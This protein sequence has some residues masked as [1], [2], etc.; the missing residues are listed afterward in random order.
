[1]IIIS[2]V[3]NIVIILYSFN[4]QL[5]VKIIEI[6][7][8]YMMYG[9]VINAFRV[10]EVIFI[11]STILHNIYLFKQLS[12]ILFVFYD[13]ILCLIKLIKIVD[14]IFFIIPL[15]ISFI[16]LIIYSNYYVFINHNY[17]DK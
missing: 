4:F 3:L 17:V 16:N 6:I 2:V 8:V 15:N 5:Y 9:S 11:I 12:V 1:M 13:I 7:S 14:F 10:Q